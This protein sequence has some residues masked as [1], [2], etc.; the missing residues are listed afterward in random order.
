MA[1][2]TDEPRRFSPGSKLFIDGRPH[3]VESVQ[4]HRGRLQVKFEAVGS[5]SEADALRGMSVTIPRDQ[6]GPLAEH[7]YYHYQ[8]L[9]IEVWTVDG[10][11]LGT[12]REIL[13]TP[14]NDVYVVRREGSPRD[15]L[16]PAL[17]DV[18]VEVGLAENRMV[19]RLPEGLA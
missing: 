14:G 2:L 7:T 5:R 8:I 1:I 11:R 10:E 3:T 13:E 4:K 18:V 15:V 17:R 16:V 6:T 12:V 19:V 9:D